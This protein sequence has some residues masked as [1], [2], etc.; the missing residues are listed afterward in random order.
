VLIFIKIWKKKERKKKT[1]NCIEIWEEFSQS[2]GSQITDRNFGRLSLH[3]SLCEEGKG[4][5]FW[6]TAKIHPEKT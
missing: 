6:R 3:Q 5:R 2:I 4:E 1:M